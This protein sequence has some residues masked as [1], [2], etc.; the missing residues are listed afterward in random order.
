M[1]GRHISKIK[2]TQVAIDEPSS[3]CI[4]SAFICLDSTADCIILF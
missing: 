1:I 3:Q 4:N 2:W